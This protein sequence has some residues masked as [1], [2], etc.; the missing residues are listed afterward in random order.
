MDIH[1]DELFAERPASESEAALLDQ[2]DNTLRA[3]LE[4]A[5]ELEQAC[6]SFLCDADRRATASLTSVQEAQVT[7]REAH[8]KAAEIERQIE[9]NAQ[10][11]LN[12]E[13]AGLANPFDVDMREMVDD[14]LRVESQ[15]L[16][17]EIMSA[18][19]N[20][21][22]PWQRRLFGRLITRGAFQRAW[23]ALCVNPRPEFQRWQGGEW[24]GTATWV[25]WPWYTR[26]VDAARQRQD[27]AAGF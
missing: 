23:V 10:L 8:E 4:L 1:S 14:E 15:R 17:G 7:L 19:V 21:M 13:A 18:W 9:F 3:D 5:L 22:R 25:E 2:E 12:A 6:V 24:V 27:E 20:A 16:Y 11:G 26:L